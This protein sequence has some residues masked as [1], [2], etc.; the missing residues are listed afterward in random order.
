M[1]RWLPWLHFPSLEDKIALHLDFAAAAIALLA[2][3]YA[4][5]SDKTRELMNIETMRVERDNDL[6][7]WINS[8]IEIIVEMEFI[9]REW[10]GP[11]DGKAIVAKTKPYL[12]KLAAAIDQGRLY[13]P[14]FSL[15]VVPGESTEPA[16]IGHGPPI[17]DHLI[18]IYN[19]VK[20]VDTVS[21]I[22]PARR[23][24][25]LKKRE[26]I[27]AAQ[28]E[29]EPRRRLLFRGYEGQGNKGSQS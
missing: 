29:I 7:R 9:L 3:W 5:K 15:D 16:Q 4:R 21:E 18:R 28:A 8:V 22:D 19:L 23:D 27:S 10:N 1:D 12:V 26:F 13:F 17:L 25:L 14:N 11:S 20:D 24:L 6:I 2:L